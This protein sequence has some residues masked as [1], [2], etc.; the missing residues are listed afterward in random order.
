MKIQHQL[1]ITEAQKRGYKTTDV[2]DILDTLAVTIESET[3]SELF[4]KGTPLTFINLRSLNYFDNKQLTK[5]A[6]SKLGIPYPK[7]ILFRN[8]NDE[9]L[10]S[11]FQKGK[12]YVCK[13]PNLAEGIGVEMNFKTLEAVQDYWSRHRHLGEL[14]LLEEQID[15]R[16]LR[17]QVIDGKIVAACTREP[18]FVIG[19]GKNDL[20]NLIENRRKVVQSQNPMNDITADKA[21]L[22]LLKNQKIDLSDIPE[23]GRKIQLKELANM[24]QG[25]VAIDVTEGLNPI[26]QTWIKRI[27]DYLNTTYFAMDFISK[28]F[29]EN[30]ENQSVVLEIN[31]QP[32]WLHHTFSEGKKHDIASMVLDSVF[33]K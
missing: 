24:S 33:G 17:V 13:P 8:P 21:T 32:E 1:I 5:V 15:G 20:N 9:S 2:S 29:G 4:I 27:C 23:K 28:D 22:D 14:F 31:A 11:F 25:A 16:D 12:T 3:K 7:S 6:L 19:D 18:A 26:F 30:A 10:K